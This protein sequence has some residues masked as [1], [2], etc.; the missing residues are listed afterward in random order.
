MMQ[1][2]K[3]SVGK[4]DRFELVALALGGPLFRVNN[5]FVDD[6]PKVFCHNALINSYF[7]C[8]WTFI[9]LLVSEAAIIQ[10]VPTL[11]TIKVCT[12]QPTQPVANPC[13]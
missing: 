3:A 12:P 9:F 7:S 1:N 6:E 4:D 13:V 10:Q 11:T 2:V 8:S 5:L